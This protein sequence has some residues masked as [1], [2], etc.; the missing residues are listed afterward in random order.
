MSSLR[1]HKGYSADPP[2]RHVY[3]KNTGLQFRRNLSG[4]GFVRPSGYDKFRLSFILLLV[5]TTLFYGQ[6]FDSAKVL[7]AAKFIEVSPF[8]C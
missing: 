2:L 3:S 8:R 6:Y 4:F 7:V 1:M 5:C